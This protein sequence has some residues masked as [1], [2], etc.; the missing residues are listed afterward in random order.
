M[1]ERRTVGKFATDVLVV[2][3]GPA[4]IAAA[5]MLAHSGVKTV[6]IDRHLEPGGKACAGG[7]TETAWRP[8]GID[9]KNPP[10][11]ANVFEELVIC[12]GLGSFALDKRE[13]LLITIDRQAWA[14]ER[15]KELEALGVDVFLGERLIGLE[16]ECAVTSAGQ[17]RFGFLIAAD[18]AVSRTKKLL[19]LGTGLVMRAWQIRVDSSSI[20]QT[21]LDVRTPKIW[22]ETGLTKSGYTWAFPFSGEIRLG[23]GASSQALDPKR[24]KR[25]FFDWIGRFGLDGR[26]GSV[27]TGAIG[28]GYVGHRFGSVFLAGDAAGLASPLTGEGIGQ[29][30]ISGAEVAR[31]IID[32]AYRSCIITALATRHRRT[33]DVLLHPFIQGPLYALAPGLLKIPFI[34]KATL[35]RYIL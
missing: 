6:L 14:R 2:G 22:F 9:P 34:R 13:P 4:G 24:L 33:H 27:E 19:G 17:R 1:I 16:K 5:S 8:A 18:G 23:C 32:P 10:P 26:S 25:M 20:C 12:A 7:L 3:A 28:C 30:L 29:A 31:E 21:E 15:I 35:N 11:W